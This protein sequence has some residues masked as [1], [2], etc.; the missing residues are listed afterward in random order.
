MEWF[1]SEIQFT[2]LMEA[3]MKRSLFTIFTLLVLMGLILSA[4][5]PAVPETETPEVETPATEAPTAVTCRY[6]STRY[7]RKAL[8][9]LALPHRSPAHR[10]SRPS[11]R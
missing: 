5:T 1:H 7:G 3:F 10:K 6:G 2:L 9:Q 11:A 8:S 4:C